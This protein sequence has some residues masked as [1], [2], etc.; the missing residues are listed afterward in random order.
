M[1]VTVTVTLRACD[2][3]I[4]SRSCLSIRSA[5][6]AQSRPQTFAKM[7]VFYLIEKNVYLIEHNKYN[8]S[9]DCN[10]SPK[11]KG[12][13]AIMMKPMRSRKILRSL[14]LWECFEFVFS[15]R[16]LVGTSLCSGLEE[17]LGPTCV[18]WAESLV[19]LDSIGE[20]TLLSLFSWLLDIILIISS[21]WISQ[22]DDNSSSGISS[23]KVT[24]IKVPAAK[25]WKMADIKR[26]K[27]PGV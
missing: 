13:S 24:C 27:W 26:P 9:T 1:T 18:E 8:L 6:Q 12:T 10:Y 7:W 2:A 14:I 19:S 11:I 25:P 20:L 4:S 5:P 23:R 22:S 15:S 16:W 3:S 17:A 21:S